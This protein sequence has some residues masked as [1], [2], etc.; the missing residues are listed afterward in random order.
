MKKD[1]F[2]RLRDILNPRKLMHSL[3]VQLIVL[4]ALAGLI[5][6]TGHGYFSYSTF[7]ETAENYLKRELSQIVE[8]LKDY[9]AQLPRVSAASQERVNRPG[10]S[11]ASFGAWWRR[12]GGGRQWREQQTAQR[13]KKTG[14]RDRRS[15]EEL[16]KEHQELMIIP[17]TVARGDPYYIPGNIADSV[18]KILID[19][20]RALV[21]IATI[22]KR[23][24]R[25]VVARPLEVIQDYV[26]WASADLISKLGLCFAIWMLV[27]FIVIQWRFR[28]VTKLAENIKARRKDDLTPLQAPVP[29]ELDLLLGA[30]NQMFERTDKSIKNEKLFLANAA[31]ELK[32]PLSSLLFRSEKLKKPASREG[33]TPESSQHVDALLT[34]ID[35]YDEIVHDLLDVNSLGKEDLPLEK[36][37]INVYELLME[38]LAGKVAKD[39]KGREYRVAGTGKDFLADRK[40]QDYGIDCPG[41]LV[42]YSDR[43]LLRL[44]ISN[45]TTNAIKYTDKDGSFT[46]AAEKS[47]TGGMDFI[48]SDNGQGIPEKELG[49]VMEAFYRVGGDTSDVPGS[50]LGLYIVKTACSRLNAAYK[51]TN[52]KPHG[53]EVRIS[54]GVE[55]FT[56]PETDTADGGAE[57]QQNTA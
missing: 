45:L 50:G 9:E 26:E 5:I 47:Q 41:D 34:A 7:V 30:L 16:F 3:Q 38:I 4:S 48:V 19:D 56:P 13:R 40:N 43:K 12:P 6:L 23:G 44:I 15:L 22:S 33:M 36:N 51:L 18:Y 39:A 35:S 20:H 28:P 42:I 54:L 1:C 53:L 14:F 17:L 2:A 27:V 10:T 31:H 21:Q 32:T 24:D 52:R 25:Y 29:S 11:R 55:V 37:R 57:K 49:K 46:L 8:A